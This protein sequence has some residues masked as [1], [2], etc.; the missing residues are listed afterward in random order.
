MILNLMYKLIIEGL[1]ENM[2]KIICL[3]I[4]LPGSSLP[5][6]SIYLNRTTGKTDSFSFI[7]T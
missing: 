7:I 5:S 3:K 1:C 6:Y 2:N 4:E